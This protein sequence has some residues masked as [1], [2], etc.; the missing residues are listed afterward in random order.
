[1]EQQRGSSGGQG[2][3][4]RRV[5]P[6]GR[7]SGKLRKGRREGAEFIIKLDTDTAVVMVI[8]VCLRAR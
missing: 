4:G 8:A 6:G 2:T 1:M 3:R 5:M 7:A